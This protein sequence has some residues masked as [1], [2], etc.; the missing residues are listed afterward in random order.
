[1]GKMLLKTERLVDRRV[2][3]EVRKCIIT[4]SLAEPRESIERVLNL[5]AVYLWILLTPA[6]LLIFLGGGGGRNVSE[7]VTPNLM[8]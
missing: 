7:T 2:T 3:L 8:L 4:I 6:M 1:M 5:R